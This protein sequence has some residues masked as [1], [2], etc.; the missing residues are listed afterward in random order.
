MIFTKNGAGDS[1][2]E[3]LISTKIDSGK[4]NE[5][6]LIVPTNRKI[7]YLRKELISRSPG[8]ICGQ[9]NLDTI[10]TFSRHLF[11]GSK[12]FK[13][14]I[15]SEAAAAVLLKQ[16]FQ[17]V[18]LKYFSVYKKNIPSGTLERVK[19]VISHYKRLGISPERLKQESQIL[20]GSE[21]LKALDISLI[22]D[23]YN[24]KINELKLFEIG[25]IYFNLNNLSPSEFHTSFRKLYPDINLIIIQGFDEFTS[26]EIDIINTLS[27][28]NN[29]RLYL[30]LDY[31]SNNPMVF[32]HLESTFSKLI[33]K[34]FTPYTTEENEK[35]QFRKIIREKLFQD[36]KD[37][38]PDFE[39]SVFE[40]KAPDKESEVDLIAKEIK[41]LI[42]NNGIL[43]RQICVVFNLISNYSRIVRDRFTMLGI[44]FNLTDRLSLKTSSPVI[45]VLNLLE[46]LENDFYY[47]NIF[48]AFSGDIINAGNL[49][50]SN[51]R[52]M[53]VNLKIIS[54]YK[55]WIDSLEFAIARSVEISEDG[56]NFEK[57]KFQK[58]LADIKSIYKLLAP[59]D[60]LLSA[61]EF[62]S[63]FLKIIESLSIYTKM[64]NRQF[65]LEENVKS[66]NL[67]LETLQEIL[68]LIRL[69]HGDT[70]FPLKFYLGNIRTAINSSRFNIR[71]KPGYGVLVTNLNE[72][73]GLEFDYL[74]IGGMT[75]GNLPTRYSPEIFFSGTFFKYDEHHSAEERYHFYQALC[76][77]QKRLY[78]T[79]ALID[80]NSELSRSIFLNEFED[81]I[82]ITKLDQSHYSG[83]IYSNEEV[84]TYFGK[85]YTVDPHSLF[86]GELP[87]EINFP[88]IK[89]SILNDQKRIQQ[90]LLPPTQQVPLSNPNLQNKLN[91]EFSV[92]QLETYAKCPYK[93]FAERILKLKPIE[94]PE[95]E[96]EGLE[97]GSLLHSILYQFYTD[98]KKKNIILGNVNENDFHIAEEL[99][100]SIAETK[101]NSVGFKSP[102]NFFEKEKILGIED[103]RQ[104]SILYKFLLEEKNNSGAFIPEFFEISFGNFS[105][106]G[107]KNTAPPIELTTGKVKVRGKID[108]IDLNHKDHT[109]KVVDYKLG[110]KKPT[111]DD[112]LNGISLQLPL[113]MYAAQKIIK[114]Q[115]QIDY[116]PAG[117]EIFSLKYRE[118]KFGKHPINI[119]YKKLSIEEGASVYEELIKITLAYIEKY[120]DQISR[121]MFNLSDLKDRENVV[122]TYCGFR[123]ICRV[124]EI[125]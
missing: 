85:N 28:V 52:S 58:A 64:V 122:C 117:A 109:F 15:L 9:M 6:L 32:K 12:D 94:E 4:L 34:K 54:G 25:D 74:F 21:Q 29:I 113:Y 17:E 96:I 33:V 71:E 37:N 3:K 60:K 35:N 93:Y 100:F 125:S 86:N 120:V 63:G 83:T 39:S 23:R 38:L 104:D 97:L 36:Q 49:D 75:D 76:S 53:A 8:G 1:D 62:E 119:S 114:D 107:N 82:R 51:L 19:N 40:I 73:R 55:N 65:A 108:R 102:L 30:E 69:E 45:S 42:N 56:Y 77:W 121:G 81:L 80:G 66:F 59:F 111:A 18:S 47:N 67:F 89:Q 48:R 22:Y 105:Y 57:P 31:S 20:T 43:P 99:I 115:L 26:P 84:L 5:L 87:S 123:P 95:E 88:E 27:G 2:I 90:L 10:G 70:K 91:D 118:G 78:F 106:S 101:I 110:G 44:P 124:Q 50:I 24:I 46:I 116:A 16:S 14:D 7:R 98:L 79:Y 72:I 13:E 103:K 41:E 11:F 68:Y 61:K 112:L 92:T